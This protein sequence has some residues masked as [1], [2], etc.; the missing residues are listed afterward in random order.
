MSKFSPGTQE[1]VTQL[2]GVSYTGGTPL[3][4]HAAMN[5]REGFDD[6]EDYEHAVEIIQGR[7]SRLRE[8]GEKLSA[9]YD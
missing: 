4:E 7:L 8:L 6:P 5:L 9:K 3:K 1:N 2:G